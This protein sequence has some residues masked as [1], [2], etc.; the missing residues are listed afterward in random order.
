MTLPPLICLQALTS[1][2]NTAGCGTYIQTMAC[3]LNLLLKLSL[4]MPFIHKINSPVPFTPDPAG[5]EQ[6]LSAYRSMCLEKQPFPYR[7][8]AHS[9]RCAAVTANSVR[10]IYCLLQGAPYW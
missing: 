1:V 8:C 10:A 4:N 3:T 7:N 9:G 5:W 6:L 2:I